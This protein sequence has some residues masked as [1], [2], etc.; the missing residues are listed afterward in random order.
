[1]GYSAATFR[2]ALFLA[3]RKP[4]T[5]RDVVKERGELKEDSKGEG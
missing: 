5:V 4:V 3:S 1:M 2:A